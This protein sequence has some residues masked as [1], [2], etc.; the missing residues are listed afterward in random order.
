MEKSGKSSFRTYLP[1]SQSHDGC[2]G[3][4]AHGLDGIIESM[5]NLLDESSIYHS[6]LKGKFGG[7]MDLLGMFQGQSKQSITQ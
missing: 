6:T 1:S 4:I 2:Q 7:F 5:R 3:G